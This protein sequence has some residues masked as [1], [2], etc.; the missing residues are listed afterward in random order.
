VVVNGGILGAHS[1]LETEGDADINFAERTEVIAG[2]RIV[3]RK[4]AYY[5]TVTGDD[6]IF[7][8]PESKIVG[9]VICCAGNFV[10]GDVGSYHGQ[11]ASIATGV[12]G[13]RY[14]K[15][16]SLKQQVLEIENKLEILRTRK[17]NKCTANAIYQQYEAELQQIQ[18]AF[19]KLNLIPATPAYS[20]N[21]PACN[22]SDAGITIHGK[23][24]ISTKLRIGNLTTTLKDEHSA[25]EFFID[26][27][28]GQIVAKKL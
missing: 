23:V 16:K 18:A 27:N 9:S 4:G 11:A 20:R 28:L 22:T 17:G 25:V 24:T 10:G 3:I 26:G 2:G 1:R 5:A 12:D 8:S 6:D 7:C 14:L 15:Y 19:R 13:K 21:E